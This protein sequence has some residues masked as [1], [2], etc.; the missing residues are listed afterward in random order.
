MPTDLRLVAHAAER[1][2]GERAAEG[3]GH[4]LAERRLAHSRGPDEGEDRP[5]AAALHHA[6]PTFG[7]QLPHGQVLEDPLLHV[8][9]P[10]VVLIEDARRLGDV[11]TVLRPHA[12][13]Q[14]EHR[15]E[16]CPDPAVLGVLLARA[17][18][19]LDFALDG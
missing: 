18:Q 5:G 10:V 3:A 4:R 17:L 13:R 8:L 1:H 6:E 19:L 11:Q 2:P 12:P 7:A 9:Q 14:L 16:P 15:V